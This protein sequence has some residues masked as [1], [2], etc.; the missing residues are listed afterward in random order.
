MGLMPPTAVVNRGHLSTKALA[1]AR[2]KNLCQTT[3]LEFGSRIMTPSREDYRFYSQQCLRW[4]EET[5]EKES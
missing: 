5:A 4:A 1:Q 3:D 2:F